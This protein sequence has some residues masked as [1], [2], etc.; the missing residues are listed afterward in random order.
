MNRELTAGVRLEATLSDSHGM[1][2]CATREHLIV[3]ALAEGQA[4]LVVDR[5]LARAKPRSP[6]RR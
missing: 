5:V 2:V 4:R 6:A 1:T 3:R